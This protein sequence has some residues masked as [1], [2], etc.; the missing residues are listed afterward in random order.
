MRKIKSGERWTFSWKYVARIH[1]IHLRFN[2]NILRKPKTESNQRFNCQILRITL[3]VEL[4][5]SVYVT[6]LP[7][8]NEINLQKGF[9][10][11][12]QGIPE[13]NLSHLDF[14]IPWGFFFLCLFVRNPKEFLHFAPISS[15]TGKK[16]AMIKTCLKTKSSTKLVFTVHKRK[17]FCFQQGGLRGRQVFGFW[18]YLIQKH[19]PCLCFSLWCYEQSSSSAKKNF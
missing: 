6:G 16:L 3:G 11:Q 17:V 9:F 5:L 19:L 12:L 13:K 14:R 4:P 18:K 10:N 8:K 2:T 7:E 1:L 15:S